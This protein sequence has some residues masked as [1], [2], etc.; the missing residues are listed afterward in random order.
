M[1]IIEN[2]FGLSPDGGSGALEAAVIL[3]MLAFIAA[4]LCRKVVTLLRRGKFT[5]PH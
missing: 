2:L 3:V 4:P 1:N 5:H